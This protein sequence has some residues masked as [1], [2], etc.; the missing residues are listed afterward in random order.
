MASW[1]DGDGAGMRLS[2]IGFRFSVFVCTGLGGC[3]GLGRVCRAW[4][5]VQGCEWSAGLVQGLG[6]CA[7][8]GRGRGARG[9]LAA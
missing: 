1:S 6:R 8:L 9:V 4:A 2:T 3:A 5:G 7:E